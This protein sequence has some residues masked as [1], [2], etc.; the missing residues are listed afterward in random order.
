MQYLDAKDE[1]SQKQLIEN[2]PEDTCVYLERSS[3]FN[4]Q[5]SRGRRDALCHILALVRWHGTEGTRA[6]S[7]R[8]DDYAN[9][10]YANM[11][12]GD[13]KSDTDEMGLE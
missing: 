5:S 8:D 1:I 11:S 4:I 7:E 12:S 6:N 13:N 2:M 3:H 9:D 10:D